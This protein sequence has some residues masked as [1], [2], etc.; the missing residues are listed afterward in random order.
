M[1]DLLT[2]LLSAQGGQVTLALGLSF[3]PSVSGRC[4]SQKGSVEG[5]LC[6]W[7]QL[8]YYSWYISFVKSLLWERTVLNT[9][10][11]GQAVRCKG[12]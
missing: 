10:G 2:M 5:H 11:K 12:W 6:G 1:R 9:Y 8:G 7:H 3:L 4:Q